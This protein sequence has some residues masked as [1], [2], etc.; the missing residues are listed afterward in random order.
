LDMPTIGKLDTAMASKKYR[1]QFLISLQS[2]R[3][4]A[5][6]SFSDKYGSGFA[7][8]GTNQWSRW[9]WRYLSV[10]QVHVECVTLYG[11]NVHLGFVIPSMRTVKVEGGGT[12]VGIVCLVGN[13]SAL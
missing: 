7:S 6:D 2:M 10:R 9:W 11:S 1:P 13:C 4:T 3:S 5:V 8:H 12:D